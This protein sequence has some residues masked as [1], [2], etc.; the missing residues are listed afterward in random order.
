ME[1][2]TFE[3]NAQK[4][5]VIGSNQGNS[6]AIHLTGRKERTTIQIINNVSQGLE[7]STSKQIDVF[8]AP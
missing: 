2:F 4:R 8:V 6:N 1:D 5:T 3:K 7:R